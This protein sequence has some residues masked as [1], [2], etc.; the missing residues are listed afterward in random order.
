MAKVGDL[1]YGGFAGARA[2]G[3]VSVGAAGDERRIQ[4]VAAGEISPT[5]TDAVNG[6]Q[7][8]SATHRLNAR[9]N[10]E[11]DRVSRNANAG[12]ASALAAG[13]LAQS[14]HPGKSMVSVSAG[15]YQGQNALAL[16]VSRVSD[17]GKI[18][19]RFAGTTNSQGKT[20]VAASWGYEW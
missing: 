12:T 4:N 9:L 20:G 11:V 5:S 19:V 18:I 2:N 16:G 8:Y 7:V 10:S 6:S 3:A 14:S 17:N 13:L 15:S 1:T